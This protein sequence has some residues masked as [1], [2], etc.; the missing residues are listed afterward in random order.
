MVDISTEEMNVGSTQVRDSA[1]EL[2][3]LAENLNE[4]VGRFK[5]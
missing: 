5:V 4:M 1:G 3:K 2:S